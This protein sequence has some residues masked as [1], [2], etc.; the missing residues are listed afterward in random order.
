MMALQGNTEHQD[1][2]VFQAHTDIKGQQ[3]LLDHRGNEEYNK[4]KEK[5]DCMEP[6]GIT[7]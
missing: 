5:T 3:A 4:L 1:Q 7:E 2:Q 6:L